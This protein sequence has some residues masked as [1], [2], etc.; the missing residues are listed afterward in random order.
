MLL[1]KPNEREF[2]TPPAGTFAARCYRF[3]DLGTQPK[4]YMGATS[5]KRMVG[6]SWELPDELMKD[7]RPFSIYQRYVWSMSEKSLLRKHLESWRGA[8]FQET[9][10][11]EGGFDT[12][13]LIGVP[14][15]LS[16]VHAV[17]GDKTYANIASVSRLMKGMTAPD[18]VNETL[19]FSL[20]D[21]DQATFDK[22][23][24]SMK[25]AISRSPEYIQLKQPVHNDNAEGHDYDAAA[26]SIP[27]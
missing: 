27:F 26:D 12:K 16:V 10:F 25:E 17:K 9:D 2:E 19:Y 6:I 13:K 3:V 14:C 4:E 23:S 20:D 1:P 21:F 18:A 11:G 15:M 7:G 22:L 8:K 5:Y 24:Q